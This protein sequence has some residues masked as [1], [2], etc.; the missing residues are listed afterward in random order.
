MS[1]NDFHITLT[2]LKL[3]RVLAHWHEAHGSQLMPTWQDIRPA[4]VKTELAIM[5]SY[6]YDAVQDEFFG[7]LAGDAIQRLIGGPIKDSRFRQVHDTD[8]SHFF[9]RAKQVLLT[10]AIFVGQGLL[11]KHQERQYFGERIILPFLGSNGREGGI[12]GATDC[13]FAFLYDSGQESTGEVEQ[14]QDL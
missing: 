8:D 5:W 11:F 4:K 7:G 6:R 1:C 9:A 3:R 13:K 14:W 2:S 10:P 12:L